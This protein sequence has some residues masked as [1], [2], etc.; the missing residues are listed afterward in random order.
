MDFYTTFLSNCMDVPDVEIEIP[1]ISQAAIVVEEVEDAMERH[2]LVLGVEPWE[3]YYIGPPD[4][5]DAYYYGEP[6]D[7]SSETGYAAV[8]GLDLEIIKPLDGDSVHGD[9]SKN[10]AKV[11]TTPPA[12]R[13]T[14]PA[15][16]P[17]PSGTPGSQSFRAGSDTAPTTYTSITQD[18]MDGAT[19]RR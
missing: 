3:V 11:S 13:S 2:R 1:E 15:K 4:Q 5:T 19:S 16:S 9:F 6:T 10:T 18:I 7:A 17:T 8:N 14:V 12:S